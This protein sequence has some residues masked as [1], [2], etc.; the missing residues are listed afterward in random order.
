MPRFSR[1]HTIRSCMV[2][3]E[4]GICSLFSADCRKCVS[5]SST[6]CLGEPSGYTSKLTLNACPVPRF[7]AAGIAAIA[8]C[9]GGTM[10]ESM[11]SWILRMYT[12]VDEVDR[13]AVAWSETTN[14][15]AT[16][17][18]CGKKEGDVRQRP[19][20]GKPS[21]DGPHNQAPSD[22]NIGKA[23]FHLYISGRILQ[24][25]TNTISRR[26]RS[27]GGVDGRTVTQWPS[28]ESSTS[29]YEGSYCHT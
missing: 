13:A 2:V 8:S 12:R 7:T 10:K 15:G 6:L 9:G 25:A 19:A 5:A 14:C 29:L 27:R 22:T 28:P 23:R 16:S 1:A 18:R 3:T 20:L 11:F 24:R 21:I 26:H 4:A 17:W